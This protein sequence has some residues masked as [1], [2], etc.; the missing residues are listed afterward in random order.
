MVENPQVRIHGAFHDVLSRSWFGR[1]WV[2]QE[3]VLAQRL[4][5][6]LGSVPTPWE[7]YSLSILRFMSNLDVRVAV[8]S[9]ANEC[10]HATLRRDLSTAIKVGAIMVHLII[11]LRTII[12]EAKHPIQPSELLL[13]CGP[14]K[15]SVPCDNVYAVA[16]LFGI[17]PI[18]AHQANFTLDYRKPH[19]SVYEDFTVWCIENEGNLDVLAQQRNECGRQRY[20]RDFVSWSTD[21][22]HTTDVAF[23]TRGSV[24]PINERNA[25]MAITHQHSPLYRSVSTSLFLKGYVID[26]VLSGF[27]A[28]R[29]FKKEDMLDWL[30]AIPDDEEAN[31]VLFGEKRPT[32]DSLVN[33][34]RETFRKAQFFTHLWRD[35]DTAAFGKGNIFEEFRGPMR[36]K[37]GCLAITFPYFDIGPEAKICAFYG[38]RALFIL[39]QEGTGDCRGQRHRLVCG[40]CFINGFEDGKGIAMARK[41]GLQEQEIRL[42]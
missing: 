39:L 17:A 33:V 2:V 24:V 12:R 26:I 37:R 5:V 22:S 27:V 19:L 1:M 3:A 6:Y 15:A 11:Q 21:W 34:Y 36:T 28:S 14:F 35:R 31:L 20:E 13:L 18:F 29:D 4:F 25:S 23:T 32:V 16:G 9:S 30:K 42:V 7:S 10:Y 38:G 41:L 40:D 8:K